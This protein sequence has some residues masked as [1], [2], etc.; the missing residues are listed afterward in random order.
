VFCGASYFQ[1]WQAIA[2]KD[3]LLQDK[4]G[5]WAAQSKGILYLIV[6]HP[7]A[8]GITNAY[9]EAV[10]SFVRANQKF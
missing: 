5:F 10:G 3:L 9:F 6:K 4:K 7:A 1:Y 2:G 8:R